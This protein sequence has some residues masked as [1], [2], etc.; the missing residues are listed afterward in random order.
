MI[1][2]DLTPRPGDTLE[3]N[4]VRQ[5]LSYGVRTADM[6]VEKC[7][8]PDCLSR[9]ALPSG[10]AFLFP[11]P[12]DPTRIDGYMRV[13]PFPQDA[14]TIKDTLIGLFY[15]AAFR[16][17]LV[18]FQRANLILHGNLVMVPLV[19]PWSLGMAERQRP[20]GGPATAVQSLMF[21][22][23][24]KQEGAVILT[25]EVSILRELTERSP[26]PGVMFRGE[27]TDQRFQRLHLVPVSLDELALPA[28]PA[29]RRY[30]G[31]DPTPV[32]LTDEHWQSGE[33]IM[34][35][36]YLSKLSRLPE[37]DDYLMRVSEF[38]L[39]KH[40]GVPKGILNITRFGSA[41]V[42]TAEPETLEHVRMT[43]RPSCPLE[44]LT[45]LTN[46]TNTPH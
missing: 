10:L 37:G 15:T 23:A 18:L 7:A 32:W 4:L 22:E 31:P 11:H 25:D 39:Q 43:L 28:T 9:T 16:G 6:R 17:V 20:V 36:A 34:A 46:H 45:L 44:A 19:L 27:R 26:A 3:T 12:S 33:G 5:L 41:G 38:I 42:I 24:V 29:V 35:D 21:Q 1:T 14:E 8:C 40:L 2:S 13:L 30:A